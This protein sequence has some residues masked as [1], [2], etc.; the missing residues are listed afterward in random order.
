M[1]TVALALFFV[2]LASFVVRSWKP[3]GRLAAADRWALLSSFAVATAAFAPA[4]LLIDWVRVPSALW[5]AAVALL[6]GGTAAAV[7]RWPE[8]PWL[9]SANPLGRVVSTGA[10]LATCALLISAAAL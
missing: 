6:A 9:A 7:L 2:P 4:A 3:R 10:T 8:L 1:D 5:L